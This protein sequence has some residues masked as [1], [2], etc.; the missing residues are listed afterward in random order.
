M[1]L[2][3]LST[4]RLARLDANVSLDSLEETANMVS[5]LNRGDGDEAGLTVQT[6][7]LGWLTLGSRMFRRCFRQT[8]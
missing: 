3:S 4:D 1:V 8:N 7:R 5:G 2:A 6:A